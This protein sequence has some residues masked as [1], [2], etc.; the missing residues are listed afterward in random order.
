MLSALMSAIAP[1]AA[2]PFRMAAGRVQKIGSM[3]SV[4]A[5]PMVIA[6]TDSEGES[7]AALAARPKNPTRDA[8][9]MCRTRSLDRSERRHHQ[10]MTTAP[11]A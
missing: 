9:A 8:M 2:A 10:T 11:I 3:A 1:A 4:P 7:T 6:R 5:A